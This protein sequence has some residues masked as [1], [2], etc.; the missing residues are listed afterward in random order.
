[1]R[2]SRAVALAAV[3][4]EFLGT[5]PRCA[6]E[7]PVWAMPVP[8]KGLPRAGLPTSPQTTRTVLA[9]AAN[10][11]GMYN[12]G[13]YLEEANGTI[14]ATWFNCP[15]AS[16]TSC[17]C[18]ERSL[19]SYSFDSGDHWSPAAALFDSIAPDHGPCPHSEAARATSIRVYPYVFAR[20]PC[21][22]GCA[23]LYGVSGVDIMPHAGPSPNTAFSE[24]DTAPK[25]MR[26][27]TFNPAG[28]V[29]LGPVFWAATP[30]AAIVKQFGFL[31]LDQMGQDVQ[32]DVRAYVAGTVGAAPNFGF[33]K[34][35]PKFD[36]ITPPPAS[37]YAA[38][39]DERSVYERTVGS[40]QRQLVLLL[41]N[42]GKDSAAKQRL[43]ASVRNLTETGALNNSSGWTVPVPTTIPDAPSRTWAGVLPSRS[44][45]VGMTYL[46]GTQVAAAP[47]D[48]L[49]VS[50]APD[51][52][53]FTHAFSVFTACDVLPL[54]IDTAGQGFSY[55]G[56]LVFNGTLF[57]AVAARKESIVLAR[58][59]VAA[60][61]NGTVA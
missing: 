1:M 57:V 60:L 35:G 59:P 10:S 34:F 19:Y 51:G 61:T 26:Q 15:R 17:T 38:S 53:H 46:L 3:L 5:V 29:A 6:G 27:V 28:K 49:M 43:F 16:E 55:P 40:S 20:I 18:G 58:M 12:D 4:L 21:G 33:L 39:L 31:T 25:I 23:R 36:F 56:G 32:I 11:T 44:S 54:G 2:R 7:L 48:P 50:L 30:S 13:P 14:V 37:K 47:R 9:R 45:S 52:T 24:Y 41:R 8:Q 22:A 42:D